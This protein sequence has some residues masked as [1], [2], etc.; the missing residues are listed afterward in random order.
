MTR[1]I[2]VELD[3]GAMTLLESLAVQAG[4]DPEHHAALLLEA[5]VAQAAATGQ[6]VAQRDAREADMLDV[7]QAQMREMGVLR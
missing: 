2:T 7:V 5:M 1:Q 6:Y 4:Q 3:D